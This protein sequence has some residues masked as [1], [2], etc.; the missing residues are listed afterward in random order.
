MAS[1][2]RP[3]R[4]GSDELAV[5]KA[6]PNLPRTE[7]VGLESSAVAARQRGYGQARIS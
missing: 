3:G 4:R 2:V 7:A 6:V 1:F 5:A